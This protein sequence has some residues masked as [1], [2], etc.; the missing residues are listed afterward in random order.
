MHHPNPGS[1]DPN[2]PAVSGQS[3][4]IQNRREFA[5]MIMNLTRR[6]ENWGVSEVL[7]GLADYLSDVLTN[8][9]AT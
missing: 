2:A 9:N 8:V 3:A 7:I 6:T 4:V 5:P 1:P